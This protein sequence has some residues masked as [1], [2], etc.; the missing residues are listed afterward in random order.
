MTTKVR[1]GD[2]SE[3]A[4]AIIITQRTVSLE[5]TLVYVTHVYIQECS[6][7]RIVSHHVPV[8]AVEHYITPSFRDVPYKTNNEAHKIIKQK[9]FN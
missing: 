6:L 4:P 5:E 2:I 3:M 1:Y 9:K 8:I 7:P